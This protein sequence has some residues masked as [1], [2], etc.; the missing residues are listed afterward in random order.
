MMTTDSPL[1]SVQ[2]L[3][4]H[5]TEPSVRILDATWFMP[6][7][8]R[9]AIAEHQASHIPGAVY[10]DIDRIAE[11]DTDLPHMVPKASAFAREVSALGISNSHR[12][13]VYDS[14]AWM[15]APRAWWMFRLFGHDDVHV[16]DGGLQAWKDAGLPVTD[17]AAHYPM[18]HFIAGFRPHLLRKVEA[19]R[20]L[21]DTGDEAIV[22][23]RSPGRFHGKEAEPRAGVR[24]GHI[25]GACCVHYRA[26]ID[27]QGRMRNPEAVRAVFRDAGIDLDGPIVASCG[28]GVSA[29]VAALSL[30]TCG[31]FDV[32]VY[33]GSWS[34]WGADHSLPLAT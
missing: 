23:T 24:A 31:R 20:R 29:A 16:L 3:A 22:D 2:W 18:Q 14:G 13:I 17:A 11:P 27:D 21:A 6:D 26:L 28:S 19:M 1:V 33:D 5:R 34:E 30:A 15:A 9:N 10:F 32:P 7:S 12:V 25:P 4:D 8:G